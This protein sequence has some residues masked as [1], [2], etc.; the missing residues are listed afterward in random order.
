MHTYLFKD[1]VQ[2]KFVKIL[3]TRLFS[4]KTG[5]FFDDY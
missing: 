5:K 1:A 3:A 2:I 4:N